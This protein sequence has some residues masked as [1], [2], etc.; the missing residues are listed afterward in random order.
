MKKLLLFSLSLSLLV[1]V[2]AQDSTH[3]KKVPSI[4]GSFFV[5][6]FPTAA[7]IFGLNTNGWNSYLAPG[8]NGLFTTGL[9]SHWDFVATLGVCDSRYKKS[10]GAFYYHDTNNLYVGQKKVLVDLSALVDYKFFTDKQVVDPYLAGGINLALYNGSYLRPGFPLGGGLQFNLGQNTFL[11]LQTLLQLGVFPKGTVDWTKENFN[12]SLG[13]SFPLGKPKKVKA[14]VAPV[15]VDMD[16]DGD[17]IP[18]SK[19]KCPTVA[20]VA[21]YDGCPIPD[22]DGDGINDDQDSCPLMPGLAKY[23]GC[24]VPDT[25]HDGIND[26]EDS[27]PTVPGIARYHGCPIPDSD[28]DGINDEEDKCP[29]EPGTVENHGCPDVQAKMNDLARDIYFK[30]GSS[31][32][33][34]RA[35]PILDQVVDIMTK[36]TSFNLEI[37]GH[38][39]NVGN[40]IMNQKISQRRADA[41]KNYFISKGINAG[42]LYGIGYGQEKPIASNKTATGRSM[43][44]RVELHAK[45]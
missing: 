28:G 38:T 3:L 32:I 22:T 25:D 30:S 27:C 42:R 2:F 36:Y 10:T 45:Y 34:P 7:K 41:I 35:V 19:D 5:K 26:E 39:D 17:G 40:P 15:P 11:Y 16:T 18:D 9:S 23:H 4:G 21:K 44:R 12:Y 43:N 31:V 1:N 33:E 29:H 37:E 6:D 13:V 8:I 24:P 20:G 14:K